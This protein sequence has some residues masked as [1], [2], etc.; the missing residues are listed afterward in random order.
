MPNDIEQLKQ[1]VTD[2]GM[3]GEAFTPDVL[4]PSGGYIVDGLGCVFL[5]LTQS[6]LAYVDNMFTNPKAPFGERREAGRILIDAII[7]HAKQNNVRIVSWA[8]SNKAIEHYAK[9]AG[10]FQYDQT[11]HQV[12]YWLNPQFKT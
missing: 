1:W 10:A 3:P 2:H 8:T 7:E 5:Y 9:H 12:W 11:P 6:T 4:P